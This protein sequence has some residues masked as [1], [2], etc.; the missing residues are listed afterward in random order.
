MMKP[1]RLNQAIPAGIFLMI[2]AT[3][4]VCFSTPAFA[5]IGTLAEPFPAP[6]PNAA[7][8][9]QR[10]LLHL[11]RLE[12]SKP[13]VLAGPIWEVMPG[14]SPES[15]PADA[16]RLLTR[17][18]FAVGAATIGSRTSECNFGIDFAEMGAASQLPHVEEMVQL[19]RLLT[20]RGKLA[21]S[22]GEWE[23]A[24]IIYFDGLR[25]GRH[26]T[27]QHTLLEALAG[28]EILRNNYHPL[29]SWAARCPTRL[30]VARAF[31]LF[32]SIQSN[33]VAPPQIVTREASIMAL[34]FQRLLEAF[35]NGDWPEKIL[36]SYGETA[37]GDSEKDRIN[38]IR[39]CVKRG[40]PKTVFDSPDAFQEYVGS[41]RLTGNRF[42]ESVAACMALPPK[43][44]LK[45]GAALKE[46]Y[47]TVI[48]VLA[49]DTLIDPAE[50][51]RLFA[52]HEAELTLTRIALAVSASSKNEVFPESLDVVA[53]RFGGSTPADPYSGEPVSYQTQSDRRSFSLEIS[54]AGGLPG[55]SFH[56]KS[57]VP[58]K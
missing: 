37:T 54:P 55:V 17:A 7:L 14:V 38:A 12:D 1:I 31:G 19:G 57:P 52:Q 27:H 42:I 43:A 33:L 34:D 9:Y 29:A 41:L 47:S 20:L 28:I 25:M 3:A 53:N 8:H 58:A 4:S 18:R 39:A 6:A 56:S 30:L 10:A 16:T 23:E 2:G 35:P 48:P 21:E 24:V 50:L 15:L 40:V 26:L 49:P 44:R 13:A 32:E 22:S 46:K 11:S 45:R 36:N 5:Q 51:G